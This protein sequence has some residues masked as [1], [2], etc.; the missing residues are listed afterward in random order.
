MIKKIIVGIILL[1]CVTGTAGAAIKL[2]IAIV[3][4]STTQEQ[5]APVRYDLPKSVGPDQIIDIGEMSLGYDFKKTI[6]YVYGTVSLK[7]SEKKVLEIEIKDVWA[8][9]PEKINFL[10]EH[11]EG[12]LKKLKFTTSSPP[13]ALSSIFVN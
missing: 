4:P 12:L 2:K 10:R 6:Y 7:P 13:K 1:V 9:P 3:N 5:T 8:I 11:T